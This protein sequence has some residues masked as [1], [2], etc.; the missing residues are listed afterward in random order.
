M[1]VRHSSASRPVRHLPQLSINLPCHSVLII[2]FFSITYFF[3]VFISEVVTTVCPKKAG[4]LS[5]D[6]GKANKRM[7]KAL[8]NRGV[9]MA[10]VNPLQ[11]GP[12]EM[13]M[14]EGNPMFAARMEA[15]KSKAGGGG[16]PDKEAVAAML[17]DL[18]DARA[19][20]ERLQ[21]ANRALRK[22]AD[23][24]KAAATV[25]KKGI[26]HHKKEFG[27]TMVGIGAGG[28]AERAKPGQG[29]RHKDGTSARGGLGRGGKARRASSRPKK[30][31]GTGPPAPPIAADAPPPP[32]PEASAP[33]A[34]G[35]DKAKAA[36]GKAEE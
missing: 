35:G 36:D 12:V 7:T 19:E 31:P 10:A 27:A 21:A 14:A 11:G 25:D 13:S 22:E 6:K 15:A 5:K 1:R 3:T 28:A 8:S 26:K 4:K 34:S 17:A 18:D 33:P 2:I 20:V 32:A 24:L 23:D 9:E 30:S 29:R 16:G